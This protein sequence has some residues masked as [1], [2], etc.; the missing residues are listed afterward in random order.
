M[1][2]SLEEQESSADPGVTRGL[3]E[4][5]VVRVGAG[6]IV[7]QLV[8]RGWAVAGSWF[9]FDDFAFMSKVMNA[10]LPDT[11]LYPYAGH[12]MPGGFF[13]SWLNHELAPLN[14][15][16]PAVELLLM[17]AVA[18]V[19]CLVFLVSAFGPRPGI[20]PPLAVYLFSV[21]TLP[22][23]I[24]WAAGV[25]QMPLQMAFFWGL[26][27]HLAYLRTRRVR[28]AV[29]T[30]LITLLSLV[31]Y[32]KSLLLFAVYAI[33]ALCY[34]TSG[35][36][37]ARLRVAWDRYRVA[38]VGYGVI[39]VGYTV[40]YA[41]WG[42]NFAP[43]NANESPIGPVFLRMVVW[44]FG[45]GILGGPL[46]WA[47]PTDLFAVAQ[48]SD[49]VVLAAGI[50][51]FALGLETVRTRSRAK[52]AWLIPGVLLASDILLVVAGRA[53]LVGPTIAQDYRYQT[54]MAGAAAV[55]IGLSLMPLLGAVESAE[56]RRPS[57]FFDMPARVTLATVAVVCLS[58]V[59]SVQYT[60]R[61]Q[62]AHESRDYFA[63]VESSLDSRKGRV[64]LVD[65]GVPA[66]IMWAFGAPENATSNVLRMY[67]DHT[68]FTD[69]ATD[70]LF[71]IGETGKVAPVV[72]PP[73]REEKRGPEKCGWLVADS[74]VSIPLD[75]PVF[76]SGWWIRVGYAS[77][78]DSP[79][80]VTAGERTYKTWILKGLHS[81]YFE[82]SGEF[83]SIQVSGLRQG[84]TLCTDEVALGMPV[85]VRERRR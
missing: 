80:T 40:F 82:A 54:E 85:P 19:G 50:V 57:A 44:G 37:V 24:W 70:S 18:S 52:R 61:W 13:L 16:L 7:V 55:A 74:A 77:S 23:G 71:I 53:S 63:N 73:V 39:A 81:L 9:Q 45:T 10:P 66:Y 64:P 28:Y 58:L 8:F 35:D 3:T 5:D 22:A 76:G 36:I 46:R 12:V 60:V 26:F 14:W 65:V 6:L 4:R 1:S 43:G 21:I 15:A 38:V 11:L 20:L 67:S 78:G 84:V 83:R 25:N 72:V 42:L 48:P 30:M 41:L 79:V 51:L 34:F 17:Q 56:V 2:T 29:L 32:E 68:R 62:S 47:H 27:T 33:V 59:S 31:F 69:V 75:G 49:L